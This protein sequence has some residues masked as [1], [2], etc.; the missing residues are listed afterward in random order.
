MT[1]ET[2]GRILI[3]DDE[4]NVRRLLSRVLQRAGF[5]VEGVASGAEAL[6]LLPENQFHLVYLDIR[7]PDMS[8]LDVLKEIR[9]SWPDL[10]VTLLTAHAS[11]QTAL[12][13]IRL[14]AK[15]YLVKPIDPEVFVA[16]TRVILQEQIIEQRK[17]ELRQQIAALQD[18]LYQ[19]Q[20]KQEAPTEIRSE[21]QLDDAERFLKRGHL[22]LDMRAQR[23]ILDDRVLDLPPTAF[24]YLAVL[25]QHA[26]E[27]VSYQ[28][29][30]SEAQGYAMVPNEAS[31]LAKYHI[32][33][34]RQTLHDIDPQKEGIID[35]L[36]GVGYRLETQTQPGSAS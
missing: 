8:G 3:I 29:L 6:R 23:A 1:N 20:Q 18:E 11:L 36:R 14:G 24:K 31:E 10:P 27:V 33:V 17:R 9:L 35:N 21:G 32:H 25:A 19:L 30:V 13:A 7:M 2:A 4:A 34:L 22:I 16:Q 12:D 5:L 26:P 28:T 15:D